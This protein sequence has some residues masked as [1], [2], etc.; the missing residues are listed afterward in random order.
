MAKG[1]NSQQIGFVFPSGSSA[2]VMKAALVASVSGYDDETAKKVKEERQWRNNYM[3]HIVNHVEAC[4]TSSDA[5]VQISKQGLSYVY[6]HFQFT[7]VDGQTVTIQ[8][9]MS[10]PRSPCPFQ[11]ATIQ[12]SKN[13]P[14]SLNFGTVRVPWSFTQKAGK[15]ISGLDLEYECVKAAA[16]GLMEPSVIEA[17]RYLN[18]DHSWNKKLTNTCFVALGGGSAMGPTL[19]LLALGATVVAVDIAIPAMWQRL[20]EAAQKLPGTLVF[21]VRVGTSSS[22]S[23]EDLASAAGCNMVSEAPEIL[24]WLQN[25]Y[26]EKHHVIGLYA[27]ADAAEFVRVALAMD[28]IATGMMDS[29]GPGKV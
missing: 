6:E 14:E 18:H 29:H 10:S 26:P 24:H 13:L 9:A 15:W 4:L 8:E 2:E 25:I 1:S 17:I 11:A 7:K 28:A 19:D 20:I 3:P 12:G 21:P 22:A 5:A 23:K 16:Q 27:Y